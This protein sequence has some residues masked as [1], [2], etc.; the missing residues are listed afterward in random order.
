MFYQKKKQARRGRGI[1]RATGEQNIRDRMII[2]NHQNIPERL[3]KS[4]GYSI[5]FQFILIYV[6]NVLVKEIQP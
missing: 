4:I 6:R 2:T 1:L 5:S 3:E